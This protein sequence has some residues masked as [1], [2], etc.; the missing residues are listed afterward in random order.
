MTQRGRNTEELGKTVL[1]DYA[2]VASYDGR[3]FPSVSPSHLW[4]HLF[5]I[6]AT[7]LYCVFLH[8]IL[9][10]QVLFSSPTIPFLFIHRFIL[11]FNSSKLSH[12]CH[13]NA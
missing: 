13:C 12:Y 4:F 6:V 7:T 10:F 5:M 8:H 9:Q 1:E 3:D 11:G 2:N